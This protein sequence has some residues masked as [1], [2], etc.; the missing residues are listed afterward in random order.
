M[1]CA[2]LIKVTP[3]SRVSLSCSSVFRVQL[4]IFSL[5]GAQTLD[6]GGI[7]IVSTGSI[8]I[9]SCTSTSCIGKNG[10]AMY[11]QGMSNFNSK[12]NCFIECVA[13]SWGYSSMSYSSSSGNQEFNDNLIYQCAK[14]KIGSRTILYLLYG[15]ISFHHNNISNSNTPA[16]DACLLR[17]SATTDARYTIIANN[18][19]SIAINID[20]SAGSVSYINILNNIFVFVI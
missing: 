2:N 12:K 16:Y 14:E 10:G 7:C 17:Y 9:D 15:S 19:V 20:A 13:Y 3:Q 8:E 11:L 1:S 5:L 6:G 4:C 18:Q